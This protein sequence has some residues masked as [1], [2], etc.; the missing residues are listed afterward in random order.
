MAGVV[1]TILDTG[2]CRGV[3]VPI[4][5][6]VVMLRGWRQESGVEQWSLG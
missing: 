3:E 2:R 6:L 5:Q 1:G 4:L